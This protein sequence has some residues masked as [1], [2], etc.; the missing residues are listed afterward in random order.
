[1]TWVKHGTV[2]D[3]FLLT[4][5]TPLDMKK[6]LI[7]DQWVDEIKSLFDFDRK[8]EELEVKFLTLS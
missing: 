3:S 6:W 8:E 7:V 5:K 1:M 4:A 2:V